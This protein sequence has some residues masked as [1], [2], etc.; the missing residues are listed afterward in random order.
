[1][2]WKSGYNGSGL[3]IAILDTGVDDTHPDLDDL[4]DDPVTFDPKVIVKND[5]TDDNTT[6]DLYGHGTHCAGIVAGTGAAPSEPYP[7]PT[8]VPTPTVTPTPASS[9]EVKSFSKVI[10]ENKVRG[11][12][13][14]KIL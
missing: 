1:M 9:S 11:S 8:P 4:D 5:F 7:T 2:L 10:G 12:E 13:Y 6:E 14:I 3:E